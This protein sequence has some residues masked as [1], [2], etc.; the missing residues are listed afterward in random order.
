MARDFFIR[1]EHR[2]LGSTTSDRSP[3][4][5]EE[6]LTLEW[7]PAPLLGE[8]NRYVFIELLGFT[9]EAFSLL[10]EKGVIG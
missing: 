6:D 5:F 3:I 1:L 9:E 7:K 8:D 4:R 2:T 10:I